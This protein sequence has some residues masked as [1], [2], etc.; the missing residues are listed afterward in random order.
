M[1]T[2]T[3]PI[4]NRL[5]APALKPPPPTLVRFLIVTVAIVAVAVLRAAFVT[6]LL[7][8]LLFIPVVLLI[9]LALGE[10]AGIYAALLSAVCA[11]VSLLDER[12]SLT[13]PQWAGSVLFVF[14]ALGIVRIASELR[15]A[16]RQMDKLL[17]E[18]DASHAVLAEREAFLSSVLGSS[19]DCIKVLDLDARLTFMTPGGQRVME[20]SD[21]NAVAGCPW[22]DFWT[23]QGNEMALS[24]IAAA[25]SGQSQNFIAETP[26]FRGNMRWWDVAVSPILG[27][28]GKPDRILSVSRDITLS[29]Q[30]D[31]EQ[32]RLA[33]I[34]ENSSDFIGMA[35]LDGSVFFL[36][37]AGLQLVGL[38]RERMSEVSL[39][40]FFPPEEAEIIRDEVLPAVDQ[41]GSWSGERT[42]RHFQT[43]ELIPVLYTVFPVQNPDGS[44]I[45]YGTVTRDFRDRKQAE[46][47]QL[48]LNN[49]L[50]HRLKNVLAVVQAVATQSL[51]QAVDLKTANTALTARLS[52][53]GEATNVLTASSWTSA[54]LREI[55]LKALAPHG[56]GSD[57]F[58]IAG[59]TILLNSDVPLGLAL[60]LHELATNAAKYG[61][62]SVAGGQVDLTWDVIEGP[63]G[64]APRFHLRWRESGGPEVTKPERRG[65]GSMMIERS[66]GAYFGGQAKLDYQVSGLVFDLDAPLAKSGVLSE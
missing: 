41:D 10:G 60:A 66:L 56:G 49:E 3:S 39:T 51:R 61:A 7:P 24:A 6:S 47:R 44:L 35:R 33:L 53:L 13:E 25:R 8:W 20:I 4:F 18:R 45:G 43:G 27:P 37:D 42:F 29:R 50:S 34:I 23:G 55:I 52:A 59:P 46:E 2:A 64:G 19:T 31:E 40:D 12:F 36:N 28:D 63:D 15:G 16:L 58:H 30:R 26:T 32:A 62:L 38:D 22:P 57:R 21:F 54:D 14:I 17:A 65:F 11:G 48:L 5:M 1:R 9:A